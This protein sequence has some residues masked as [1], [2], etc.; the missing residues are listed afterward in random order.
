MV[1]LLIRASK[2]R[3]KYSTHAHVLSE[4]NNTLTHS[5]DSVVLT[6]TE[7]EKHTQL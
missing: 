4:R 2:A 5:S 7:G 6:R 3:P 1:T